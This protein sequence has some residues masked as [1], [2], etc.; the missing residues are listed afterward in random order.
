MKECPDGY[1]RLA[2]FIDSDENFMQYRRFGF[3]QARLLLYKQDE[4]RVLESRLDHLDGC[5]ETRQPDILRSREKDDGV[6]GKRKVL[7]AEINDK[8]KEYGKMFPVFHLQTA[9][10]YQH[11]CW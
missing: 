8:F 1:P 6:S 5:D 3:L 2:A 9:N 7:I 11:G 10:Q 4:L